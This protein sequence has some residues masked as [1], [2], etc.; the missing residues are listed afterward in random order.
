[1][2]ESIKGLCDVNQTGPIFLF[3]QVDIEVPNYKTE[4][5]VLC[6]LWIK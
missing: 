4:N 6:L 5:S 3:F 1:M 2:S